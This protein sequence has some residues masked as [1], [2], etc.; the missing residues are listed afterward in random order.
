[1]DKTLK[2]IYSA[3]SV[4]LFELTAAGSLLQVSNPPQW[5]EEEI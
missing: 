4:I 1:M 5:D 2:E 3:P